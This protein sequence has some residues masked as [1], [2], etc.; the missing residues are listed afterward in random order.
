[1]SSERNVA[2]SDLDDRWRIRCGFHRTCRVIR[3]PTRVKK[4]KDTNKST[5]LSKLNASF[6]DDDDQST[7]TVTQ[8]SKTKLEFTE[9]STTSRRNHLYRRTNQSQSSATIV[10]PLP[11]AKSRR[12]N[13][14]TLNNSF[15]QNKEVKDRKHKGCVRSKGRERPKEF[16]TLQRSSEEQ[17][18]LV[19]AYTA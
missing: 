9:L 15:L 1:M 3:T 8:Q 17:F 2:A 7:N 11:A 12:S 4:R 18:Y 16:G 5:Y 10:S 13:K 6:I 14:G 19:M